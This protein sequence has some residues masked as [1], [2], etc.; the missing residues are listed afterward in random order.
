MV[1]LDT[2]LLSRIQFGVTLAFHIIF[3]TLSIGLAVFLAI[4]EALW[5]RTG[6]ELYFFIYRFWVKIFGVSFGMGVVSGIVLSFE[7][8][9]NFSVFSAS[10]GNVLGPLLGYEVMTAFFLEASFLGIMLFAWHRVGNRLHFIATCMVALGTIISAFWIL[11]ANS[12]MHTPAG[13]RVEDGVFYVTDWS[14]AIFNPSFPYRFVHMLLA[15]FLT[16]TF[17]IAGVAAWYLLR[18]DHL[19]FARR[20]F[21][22]G[23]GFAVVLAPAQILVGDMHGLQVKRDQPMKVAAMEAVWETERGVPFLI[24]ALPDQEAATNHM[25]IGIPYLASLILTHHL[26]GE[27][28][29]LDQVPPGDRPYVP[30]VFFAFRAMLA[31]GTLF[32]VVALVGLWLRWRGALY[33]RRWFL[34]LCVFTAPLGFVATIAGWIVTEVGRQPWVVYGLLRTADAAS[35]VSRQAVLSSLSLFIAVYGVLFLAFLYY[36]LKLVRTGPAYETKRPVSKPV[37]TA[38][39]PGS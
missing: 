28:A 12:W 19:Q 29:G 37:R 20:C 7:F 21:S 27:I 4:I 13:F 33:E 18:G 36:F 6:Q 30:T 22:L 32:L 14:Q 31:I 24:F 1:E 17:V 39:F 34:R 15:A 25:E 5:L 38:W 26:E 2:V 8:G 3:P 16:T 10:T 23:L 11:A 9:T 35:P